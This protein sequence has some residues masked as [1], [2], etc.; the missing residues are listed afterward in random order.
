[1]GGELKASA[2]GEDGIVLS[3]KLELEVVE[4]IAEDSGYPGSRIVAINDRFSQHRKKAGSL[5]VLV[6]EDQMSSQIHITDLLRRAGYRVSAV[7]TGEDAMKSMHHRHFSLIFVDLTLPGM[8]GMQLLRSADANDGHANTR[9][10]MI[11]VT[12]DTAKATRNACYRAGARGFLTKPVSAMQLLDTIEATLEVEFA[13]Q[14][15]GASLVNNEEEARQYQLGSPTALMHLRH[16]RAY[17]ELMSAAS[18]VEDWGRLRYAAKAM[19]GIGSLLEDVNLAE[20]SQR[21][22]EA[23]VEDLPFSAAG[24][25]LKIRSALDQLVVSNRDDI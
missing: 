17:M 19:R 16:G 6:V 5:D 15:V 3:L 24:L 22:I 20:A 25:V 12:G 13:G 9:T 7:S 8:Q 18:L 21:I 11:V 1:M 4:V 2:M 10:P 23:R 14:A